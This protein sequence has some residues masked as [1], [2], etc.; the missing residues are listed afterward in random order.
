MAAAAR[1]AGKW[2]GTVSGGPEHTQRLLDQGAK[3]VCHGADI[4]MVKQGMELIQQRY[5]PLG[6]TFD[7]RLAAQAAELE[8]A[9]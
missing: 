2:W 4:L 1:S 3:F 5:A 6:F 9:G 8:Q 7:N